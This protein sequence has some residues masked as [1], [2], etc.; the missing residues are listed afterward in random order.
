[1]TEPR[2]RTKYTYD[3]RNRLT[4]L[5]V[6][7]STAAIASYAYTLDGGWPGRKT[8]GRTWVA[9]TSVLRVGLLTPPR[10]STAISN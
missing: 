2:T 9:H 8:L 5:G 1:M 3:T 4:N 7:A 6:N 10:L